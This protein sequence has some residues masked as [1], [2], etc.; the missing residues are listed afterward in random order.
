MWYFVLFFVKIVS[1]IIFFGFFLNFLLAIFFRCAYTRFWHWKFSL[2]PRVFA[3]DG[4]LCVYVFKAA[5]YDEVPS[6]MNGQL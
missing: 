2:V 6:W 1:K 3:K 4:I 5:Y